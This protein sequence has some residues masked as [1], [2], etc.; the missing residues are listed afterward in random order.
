MLVG[1][2]MRLALTLAACKIAP[3]AEIQRVVRAH[4]T[5]DDVAYS[6]FAGFFEV[7][8]VA[9]VVYDYW[10][11]SALLATHVP[12]RDFTPAEKRAVSVL[13]LRADDAARFTNFFGGQWQAVTGPFGDS[14]DFSRLA[15]LPLVGKRIAHHAAQPQTERY[16]LQIFRRLSAFRASDSRPPVFAR[17]DP[18]RAWGVRASLQ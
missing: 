7:K 15:R 18:S 16:Q 12:G 8:P 13:I 9:R 2:P 14:Q 3:R 11:S 4:V 5:P 17:T 6:D 1:L 10:S